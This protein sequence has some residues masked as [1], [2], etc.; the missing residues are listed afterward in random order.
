MPLPSGQSV[1]NLE[2]L[3]LYLLSQAPVA[4]VGALWLGSRGRAVVL[5]RVCVD[6]YRDFS[7]EARPCGLL[8]TDR[9]RT[10]A[11]VLP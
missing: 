10:L 9:A 3:V 11:T 1:T 7:L 4:W 5:T 6:E 2:A 8:R